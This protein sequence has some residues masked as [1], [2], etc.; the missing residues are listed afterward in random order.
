MAKSEREQLPQR[1]AVLVAVL[2]LEV[3]RYGS[4]DGTVKDGGLAADP[5]TLTAPPPHHCRSPAKG[6]DFAPLCA[7]MKEG[8]KILREEPRGV[9]PSP[10]FSPDHDHAPLLCL[11]LPKYAGCGHHDCFTAVACP[12]MSPPLSLDGKDNRLVEE[13]CPLTM[14]LL[15]D[16]FLSP[17]RGPNLW[18]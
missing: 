1:W 6:E 3:E 4:S 7:M 8:R 11:A 13:L 10:N 15:E 17:C 12:A 5:S 2:I 16:L 18:A 14:S 9:W